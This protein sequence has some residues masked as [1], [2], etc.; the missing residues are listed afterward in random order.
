MPPEILALIEKPHLLIA[1]LFIGILLGMT[2]ERLHRQ[3]RREMWKRK[4]AWRDQRGRKPAQGAKPAFFDP[5]H[6]A[7]DQLR[8]VM[9]AD[10][11]ARPLLSRS[12]S[13]LFGE[14]HKIIS[15]VAPEWRVMAQV[16]LGEFLSAKEDEAFRCINS[17]RVD[18][19]LI[20]REWR[21]IHAIE[22]QG[23]AHHQGTAAARDATK[24][25][26]LRR[27]GIGF[28]EIVPGDTPAELRRFI[29]K[30]AKAQQ[31]SAP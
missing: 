14:L 1:L 30:L 24:K 20:D 2:I 28:L 16:N 17:K 9:N 22:Y 6:D 27:A 26:A 25:E 10:F 29:E 12:E 21:P 19:L 23:R 11:E 13:R 3:L 15:D 5:A 4:N 18:L 8:I 7:A 31:T